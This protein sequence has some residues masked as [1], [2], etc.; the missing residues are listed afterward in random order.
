MRYP[1]PVILALWLVIGSVF[2]LACGLLAVGR[3]RSAVGWFFTGLVIGPIA[4]VSL[5][6]RQRRE[7]PSFL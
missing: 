1:R 6:I 4:L 7:E 2:G 5:V 3:N